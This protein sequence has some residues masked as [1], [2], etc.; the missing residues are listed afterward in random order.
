MKKL[1]LVAALA[2]AGHVFA[3]TKIGVV[4]MMVLV[5]NHASYET[6]RKLLEGKDADSQKTI[7]DMRSQ[8]ES[9]EEE[10]RKLAESYRNPMLSAAAKAKIEKD[11]S[12]IQK[13]YISV[14]QN[15]REEAMRAQR[16]LADFEARLLKVQMSDIN[17]KIAAYAKANGYCAVFDRTAAAFAE[18]SLDVTDGV[19]KEMGVDPS[20]A[21]RPSAEASSGEDGKDAKKKDDGKQ[22]QK[23][24]EAKK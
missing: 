10:G 2:A 9:I 1:I 4:D 18:S 19:L 12:L 17:E 14:Q 7:D 5:R 20:K 23:K 24:Q 11:M 8:A 22:G 13:R 6:N 16:E 15:M 21:V 3:E